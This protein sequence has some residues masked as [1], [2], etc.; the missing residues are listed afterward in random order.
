MQF[1]AVVEDD[2]SQHVLDLT[3]FACENVTGESCLIRRESAREQ[4][5]GG[6]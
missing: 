2:L 5:W 6:A 1:N 3:A 4:R